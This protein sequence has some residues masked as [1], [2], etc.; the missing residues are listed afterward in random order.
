[1]ARISNNEYV[2]DVIAINFPRSFIK[3]LGILIFIS[4]PASFPI[5]F[6]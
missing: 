5:H 3:I 4:N 2:I 6:P 1:M